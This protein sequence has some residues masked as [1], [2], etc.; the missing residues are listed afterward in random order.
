LGFEFVEIAIGRKDGLR[1]QDLLRF[2]ADHNLVPPT[3]G[4][5]R[6]RDKR[7]IIPVRNALAADSRALVERFATDFAKGASESTPTP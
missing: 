2:L 5:I 3:I 7:T 4:H 1:V 6:V